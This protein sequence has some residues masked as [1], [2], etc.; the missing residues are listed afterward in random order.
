MVDLPIPSEQ[1]A[2]AEMPSQRASG[3]VFQTPQTV[4]IGSGLQAISEGVDAIA[5]TAAAEQ[6]R[7]DAQKVVERDANGNPVVVGGTG[8]EG[9]FIFGNAGRAYQH[10]F[11]VGS[12]AAV[13][14]DASVKLNDLRNQFPGD[15]QSFM[16]AAGKYADGLRSTLGGALGDA[17]FQHATRLGTEYYVGAVNQKQSADTA[18]NEQAITTRISDLKADIGNIARGTSSDSTSFLDSMAAPAG[19]KMA[20]LKAYYQSLADNPL[21]NKT[22]TQEKIDSQFKQFRQEATNQWV[23]GNAQR[24]RDTQGIDAAKAWVDKNTIGSDTNM[25]I[26]QREAARNQAIAQI[27][28]LTEDQKAK[29]QASS[30][31]V[32]SF[33]QLFHQGTPPNDEQVQAVLTSAQKSFDVAG[34]AR[35]QAAYD[36]YKTVKPWAAT[37]PG[38]AAA[39][40]T[41]TPAGAQPWNAANMETFL[42]HVKKIENPSGN[43]AAVSPTGAGGDFQFTKG[44]WAQ[45]GVGDR[46]DPTASR[47]AARRLTLANADSLQKDLGRTP[48]EGE[49]YLAHQQG[50]AGAAA[51]LKNPNANVV[52]ALSAAYGGDV[53]KADQAIRVNG[54]TPDMTA[55]QFAAKW[56]NKFAGAAASPSSPIPYTG[57]QIAANPWIASAA[58]A[59]YAADRPRQVQW[60]RDQADLI[61]RSI[62]MGAAPPP[63]NVAQVLQIAA[64]NP[65]ELGSVATKLRAQVAASPAAMVAAGAQDGGASYIQ[66]AEDMARQSPD[67]SH[68]EFASA[69]KSQIEGRAKAFN[70]NPHAYAA[71]SDVG[72]IKQQPVPLDA[73]GNPGSI[74]AVD[75]MQALQTGIQQRREAAFQI[76][77]RT[78]RAPLTE[79][80]TSNDGKDVANLLQKGDGASADTLLRGLQAQLH[81]DEMQALASNKDFANAVGG[82]TRSGD[83]AKAGAAFSFMDKQWRENPEAFKEEYGADMAT[84]L[85]VWQ[86]KIAFMSPDQAM[87]EMQRANDPN[88]IKAMDGLREQADKENKDLTG[89]KVVSKVFGS[90]VP[91]MSPG[92]PV[93]NDT[94]GSSAAMLADYRAAYRDLYAESGGDKTIADK[95]ALER[96]QMKWGPSDLNGGRVMQYPP[97][98]YYPPDINGSRAYFNNQLSQAVVDAS[99]HMQAAGVDPEKLRTAPRALVADATTQ[100]DVASRRAPSYQV[101]VQGENG[102]QPLQAAPGKPFRFFADRDAVV[103][104]Q[105]EREAIERRNAPRGLNASDLPVVGSIANAWNNRP[106]NSM[107]QPPPVEQ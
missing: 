12:L 33:I 2:T 106:S 11:D 82:L 3:A 39:A 101:I 62:S 41:G 63:E 53:M 38:P 6:G 42:D 66:A 15:P 16:V 13:Q 4:G 95:R 51:L 18:A 77:A 94:N 92:S 91:F 56:T 99:A 88:V 75:P 36:A 25:P 34:A 59:Q 98:R 90:W 67:L 43:P 19:A 80:F 89:D 78:G 35:L 21:F 20:E 65:Q 46:F 27:A 61:G 60:A 23:V 74:G 22:Y 100:Q 57:A 44:T 93:S 71:R 28:D 70:E 55:G 49:L 84:R 31:A 48:T 54:G 30:A 52:Q 50:A 72:W 87:R 1:L 17:A 9:H 102:W 32:N 105:K 83:P 79:M 40:L 10:A 81:P 69:I 103:D 68:L 96:V 107:V 26:G 64:Q 5:Q 45:F 14:N 24:I 37:G 85:A 58:A 47:D 29:Q 73:V 8:D 97:E 76:A 104:A 7:Q 86:D